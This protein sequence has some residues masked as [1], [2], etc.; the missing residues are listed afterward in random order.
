M[1]KHI[2]SLIILSITIIFFNNGCKETGNPFLVPRIVNAL[3]LITKNKAISP[4]KA[5]ADTVLLVGIRN[6]LVQTEIV[7][8]DTSVLIRKIGLVFSY[9]NPLPLVKNYY[10]PSDSLENIVEISVNDTGTIIGN[11]IKIYPWSKSFKAKIEIPVLK[12]EQSYYVRSYVIYEDIQSGRIDTGY[13]PVVKKF[14]TKVPE[15]FWYHRQNYISRTEAMAISLI[16]NNNNHY[17]IIGGGWDNYQLRNDYWK[18]EQ[19]INGQYIWNQLA[20][21]TVDFQPRMSGI[22]AKF[23][24]DTLIMG[25]GITSYDG[26]NNRPL[27]ISKYVKKYAIS[28]NSWYTLA[29]DSFPVPTYDAVAFTLSYNVGGGEKI[30]VYVLGGTNYFVSN[31]K[32][33]TYKELYYY[34]YEIDYPG[35][36]ENAW[37][38]IKDFPENTGIT[39]AVAIT[40]DNN[41]III[42]GGYY[43]NTGTNFVVRSNTVYKYDPNTNNFTNL[44]NFT[45]TPRTN[46]VGFAIKYTK[47]NTEYKKIFYGTGRKQDG[48]LLNDWW[49]LDLIQGKWEQKAIIHDQTNLYKIDTAATREG[50]IAFY[51]KVKKVDYGI[52][53]RG[54]LMFGKTKTKTNQDSILNDVWEYLP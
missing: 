32:Y 15:D 51:M 50:A 11:N 23:R 36:P 49:S 2:F 12:I 39:Q 4:I 22:I 46:A 47:N 7:Y 44:A 8:K 6:A 29:M 1:R 31:N 5:Y 33:S 40:L 16:D 43:D 41:A 9:N 53:D 37:K 25:L 18:F 10:N 19:N 54:F 42:G 3:N 30:R 26:I 20:N 28:E 21:P 34:D 35:N 24:G 27:E 52:I 48:T 14:K 45:G 13:N 17:A 38:K